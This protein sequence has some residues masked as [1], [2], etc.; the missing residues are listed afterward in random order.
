V[1]AD[2]EGKQSMGY[3]VCSDSRASYDLLTYSNVDLMMQ[4]PDCHG[5]TQYGLCT[6]LP[7]HKRLFLTSLSEVLRA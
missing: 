7:D 6:P 5:T 1:L 4:G 2:D 3:S